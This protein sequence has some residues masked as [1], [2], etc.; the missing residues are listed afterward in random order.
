MYLTLSSYPFQSTLWFFFF[1]YLS[2]CPMCPCPLCH[3]SLWLLLK[4]NLSQKLLC[5]QFE[6]AP[7]AT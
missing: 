1:K 7:S 6:N 3:L 5:R 4:E 2:M